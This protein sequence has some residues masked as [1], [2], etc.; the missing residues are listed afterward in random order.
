MGIADF[1]P[2]RMLT[3]IRASSCAQCHNKIGDIS[4]IATGVRKSDGNMT[5]PYIEYL[6]SNCNHRGIAIFTENQTYGLYEFCYEIIINVANRRQMEKSKFV[7]HHYTNSQM[8]P[9]EIDHFI[10]FVRE[11]NDHQEFLK[12]IGYN[13]P[14]I[15]E[16][17]KNES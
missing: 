15:K 9:E 13:N 3:A 11:S 12:Y 7:E 1:L 10:K 17:K 5:V 14:D 2:Y 4:I 16:K 8:T 6:C